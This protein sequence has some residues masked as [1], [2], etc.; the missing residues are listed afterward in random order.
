M[1]GFSENTQCHFSHL[2]SH[3]MKYKWQKLENSDNLSDLLLNFFQYYVNFNFKKESICL[4]TGCKLNKFNNSAMFIHNPFNKE[5]NVSKNV[6]ENEVHRIRSSMKIAIA[7][8]ENT[9]PEKS[10][11]WG[12]LSILDFPE[13]QLH[14]I[15]AELILNKKEERAKELKAEE[16]NNKTI[17]QDD[18]EVHPNIGVSKQI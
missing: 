13:P 18:S 6:N 4:R 5:L 9:K 16:Q 15:R 10:K 11:K 8:L 14:S 3:I 1:E 17:V 12:I 7:N 2:Y